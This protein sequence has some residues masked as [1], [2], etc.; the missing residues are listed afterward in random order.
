MIERTQE[1][2]VQEQEIIRKEKELDATVRKPAEAE[3]YKLEK[4]AEAHRTKIIMEAEAEAEALRLRGEA[5]SF[6]IE[7]KAKAEA[8]QMAKK[9]NAYKEYDQAA[10]VDMVLDT[11]PKVRTIVFKACISLLF[12]FYGQIAAEIAA[13][14]AQCNRVVMISNGD[15]EVGAGKLTGEVLDIITKVHL[16][17]SQLTGTPLANV[18]TPKNL[19][20]TPVQ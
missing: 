3:K 20:Q 9:A 4:L 11:L 12:L 19:R 2:Q 1:I 10:K 17:V 6:A 8:E 7:A 15:G 13:P 14:L 18:S 16:T 5:E